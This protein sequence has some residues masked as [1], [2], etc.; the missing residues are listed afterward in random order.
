MRNTARHA[1]ARHIQVMLSIKDD[2]MHFLIKDN[3]KG[4]NP[5][6]NMKNVGLGM[7]SMRERARLI[8]GDLSIKSQLGKGTVIELRAP[9]ASR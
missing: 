5:A 1:K 4:F 9:I 3:G 2:N 7:A 6:S 8:Q